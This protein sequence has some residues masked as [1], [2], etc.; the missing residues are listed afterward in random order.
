MTRTWVWTALALAATWIAPW[1]TGAWAVGRTV[2]LI[3]T[4]GAAVLLWLAPAVLRSPIQAVAAVILTSAVAAPA[5]LFLLARPLGGLDQAWPAYAAMWGM[6][7]LAARWRR[8]REAPAPPERHGRG[9][10]AYLVGAVVVIGLPMLVNPS[11]HLKSDA[12][13]HVALVREILSEPYPWTD[14]R[15][16]GQPLRYFWFFNYWAAGFASRGGVSIPWSL[17]LMNL[18]ALTA[19]SAAVIALVR[20]LLAGAAGRGPTLAVVLLGCNPLGFY[21]IA[22]QLAR[23][24]GGE[25][26]GMAFFQRLVDQLHFLDSQ[27]R[28][29]LTPYRTS[30][31]A[32]LNKFFVITPYGFGMAAAVLALLI[33]IESIRA[34]RVSAGAWALLAATFAAAAFHHAVAAVVL[35]C[36]VGGAI[37]GARLL[38]R[39]PLTW[40]ATWALIG[41]MA[42]AVLAAWPYYAGILLG[43]DH[44]GGPDGYGLGIEALWVRTALT[45]L[46]PMLLMLWL[47]RRSL[48]E[49]LGPAAGPFG[50]LVTL[51]LLMV[52]LVRMPTVNE[53]KLLI[54]V[55]CLLAPFAVFGARRVH[56]A[57]WRRP[58]ARAAWVALIAGAAM[59]PALLWIGYL[60]DPPEPAPEGPRAAA[61]WLRG[62][63]PPEAVLIELV[64]EQFLLNRAERDL[65]VSK[66]NF[67]AECG[68]PRGAMEGRLALVDTLYA[69]GE[70]RPEQ[71]RDLRAL[72]RPVYAFYARYV[73]GGRRFDALARPSPRDF[74]RV[75]HHPDAEVYRLREVGGR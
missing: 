7:L 45:S 65:W 43:R 23:A 5:S 62:H 52:L 60:L 47:G 35:G 48:R 2:A 73:E 49:A 24:L 69:S 3:V 44:A 75:F 33:V 13:T 11:L 66:P 6:L 36:T 17:A 4:P 25:R 18:T 57:A 37:L 20:R 61:R 9:D 54:L 21:F 32:W 53:N 27:V 16:A 28:L 74:K 29:T 19:F 64:E 72:G 59:V 15:F 58:G 40:S 46:G 1:L 50:V 39:S 41:A 30:P 31:V 42:L 10:L 8:C 67:I 56:A 51:G 26:Q 68:Y 12:W 38:K 71:L 55:Y 63:T 14:P 22:V 70:L 34:R